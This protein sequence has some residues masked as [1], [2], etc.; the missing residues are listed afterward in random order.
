MTGVMM[1]CGYVHILGVRA[2]YNGMSATMM[3]VAPYAGLKFMTYESIKGAVCTWKGLDERDLQGTWFSKQG[4]WSTTIA[5]LVRN[6]GRDLVAMYFT[7]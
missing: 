6:T 7:A 3:G 5:T 1:T 4:S 2:L